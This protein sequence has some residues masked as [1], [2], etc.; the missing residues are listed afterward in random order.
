MP[1]TLYFTYNGSPIPQGAEVKIHWKGMLS[2]YSSYSAD[3]GGKITVTDDQLKGSSRK[4]EHIYVRPKRGDRAY[5]LDN[6]TIR[7]NDASTY[8]VDSWRKT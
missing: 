8:A 3:A 5:A 7:K 1:A 6:E 2:G 4:A